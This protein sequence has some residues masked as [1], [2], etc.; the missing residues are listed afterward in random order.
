M[1]DY[2]LI[3]HICQAPYNLFIGD[4][5][6]ITYRRKALHIKRLKVKQPAP[7]GNTRLAKP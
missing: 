6:G 3:M 1:H 5:A 7:Q 2:A 4:N